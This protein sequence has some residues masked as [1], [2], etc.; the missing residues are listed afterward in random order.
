MFSY[1]F[2]VSAIPEIFF[3]IFVRIEVSEVSIC[4]YTFN[5]LY[6]IDF[7]MVPLE[8]LSILTFISINTVN[9]SANG[10]L[11]LPFTH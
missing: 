1:V 7:S 10:R 3:F 2:V 6:R 5:G 8:N 9:S 11:Y 4:R